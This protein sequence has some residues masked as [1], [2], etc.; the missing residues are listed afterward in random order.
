MKELHCCEETRRL[1]LC[2][3][4]KQ[5]VFKYTS[6]DRLVVIWFVRF[7]Q[8]MKKQDKCHV[9]SGFKRICWKF[10]MNYFK[11]NSLLTGRNPEWEQVDDRRRG[12][13][14]KENKQK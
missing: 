12:R 1:S 2:C 5:S 7:S 11:S 8:S 14:Q 9:W 10:S 13:G 4:Q 3:L 6:E